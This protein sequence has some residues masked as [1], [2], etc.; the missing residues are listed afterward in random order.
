MRYEQTEL[1]QKLAAEYVLGTLQGPARRRFEQLLTEQNGLRDQ[2]SAW[3]QRLGSWASMLPPQAVPERVWT[4]I[5]ARLHPG[6]ASPVSR[7]RFWQ[8]WAWGSTALAA[9]LA[10]F[11][12]LRPLPSTEYIEVPVL[13]EVRDLAVLGA[14]GKATRWIV[15][16][17]PEGQRLLLSALEPEALPADKSLELWSIPADGIPRSLGLI[18]AQKGQVSLELDP[19]R[20]AR[21]A[22][23]TVLAISL[24]PAGG[25]PTGLPTGPVLYTGKPQ[26]G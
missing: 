1:Q 14:E 5:Q 10:A 6:T 8:W 22:Q 23:A 9:G 16:L 15:R 11:L 13:T 12:L 18:Q 2:V 19:A 17:E 20:Q 7:P 25:S 26:P 21:L 3:E 24:E 4:G